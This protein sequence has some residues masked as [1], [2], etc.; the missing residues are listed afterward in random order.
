MSFKIRNTT[1]YRSD[2][3]SIAGLVNVLNKE[4]MINSIPTGPTGSTSMT[5]NIGPSRTGSTGPS[6]TGPTGPTG[7]NITG[8]TG[9]TGAPA[10]P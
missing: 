5:G 8:P 6:I 9:P 7:P 1:E 2:L 10:P 4:K 3:F